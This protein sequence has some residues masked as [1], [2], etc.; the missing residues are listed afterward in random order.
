[1][2]A[3]FS[4][5]AGQEATRQLIQGADAP[6]A[7][8]YDNDLMAVAA[9]SALSALG[10][11]VPEEVNVLAW[12]DSSLCEVTHPQLSAM[13]HDVMGV[14]AHVA[15][16]LFDLRDGAPPAAYLDATPTFRPRGS[17]APWR[18]AHLAAS[19]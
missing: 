1:M 2:H 12:D 7:I 17:T 13:S 8:L 16:R 11:V 9:L 10:V 15:R 4:A 3:D 6:T 14:G 18:P 19:R 5:E